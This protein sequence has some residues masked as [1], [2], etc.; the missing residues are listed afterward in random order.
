MPAHRGRVLLNSRSL[1]RIFNR[2]II[3]LSFFFFLEIFAFFCESGD[4]NLHLFSLKT[5]LALF[6]FH[7]H[8]SWLFSAFVGLII[9]LLPFGKKQTKER[10]NNKEQRKYTVCSLLL[11][12]L[13]FIKMNEDDMNKTRNAMLYTSVF[14]GSQT[15][16]F[17]SEKERKKLRRRRRKKRLSFMYSLALA[18]FIDCAL[19]L[20]IRPE[21]LCTLRQARTL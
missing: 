10:Q 7:Y 2:D 8:L 13:D 18:L 1:R 12:T 9:S 11:Q 17:T 4:T 19:Y 5:M 16:L 21:L 3:F 15:L 20:K 6:E 14:L